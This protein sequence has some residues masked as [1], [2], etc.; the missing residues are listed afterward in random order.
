VNTPVETPRQE[1]LGL[2]VFSSL[3]AEDEPWLSAC[4][5]PPPEFERVTAQQS[6]VAF[7]APG[8]GKTALFQELQTRSRQANGKPVRLLVNWR[9]PPLPPDMQ[10]NL[11]WVKRQTDHILDA[12]AYA[13]GHHLHGNPDDYGGAPVWARTRL[14]WFIHRFTQPDPALRLGPLAEGSS[15]GATLIR[16]ILATPVRDVL[17][18]DATPDQIV[19]ELVSALKTLGLDDVWVMSDGLEGW[20]EA[21]PDRLARS[22]SAFLSTLP[23]FERSGLVYKLCVPANLEPALSHASGLIRRRVDSIHIQWNT[24]E[25]RQLVERR[26]ALATGQKMFDLGQLCD[27]PGFPGWLERVGGASPREWLDQVT[28]LVRCYLEESRSGPIDETAWKQLR[29]EH[30]PRLYLDD[31]SRTVI[32]GGREIGLESLPATAYE[33]L[34]YLYQR[35]GQV[36]TKA[37]LYFLVCRGLAKVPRSPADEHYEGRKVYEGLVDT[38]LWR[39]RAAIEPEP[40]DPVLLVTERGHGVVLQVR[41]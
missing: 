22:L 30:P 8:S 16:Q 3:R 9:P 29:S 39:L 6:I 18:E 37:E 38:T 24:D 34:C 11:V 35:G 7:G 31:V 17:Y 5:V 10:P 12:C 1:S 20:A 13:L 4:F 19:A 15:E 27:A 28:P 14:V 33:M 26:L 2:S 23:L 40:S 36:V 32:V 21:D 25:L 41:W